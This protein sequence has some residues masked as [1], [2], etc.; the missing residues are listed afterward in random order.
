MESEYSHSIE[1]K[2]VVM[3]EHEKF[4]Q[5]LKEFREEKGLNMHQLSLA[6]GLGKNTVSFWEKRRSVPDMH[7]II[8]ICKFFNCDANYLIGLT[9]V[10]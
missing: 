2:I 7:S 3:M 1:G 9:D 4:V 8:K 5:R 10:E 6:L